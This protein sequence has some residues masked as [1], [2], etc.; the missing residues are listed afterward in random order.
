MFKSINGGKLPERGSKYSACV[1]VFANV[2]VVIGAGETKMIGLGVC[3]DLDNINKAVF[4]DFDYKTKSRLRNKG[5]NANATFL[6]TSKEKFLKSHYLQLMLR[7]SLGKKGLILPNGVG[8]IDMDYL[9]EIKMLIH[10]PFGNQLVG[11]PNETVFSLSDF[12]IVGKSFEIKKG[13]KIGQITLLEHKSFLFGIHS[14]EERT[15][16]FGSSGL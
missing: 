8:V 6:R 16:G 5:V 2:D 15:G 13:D 14:E 1:D 12:K 7:S 11:N 4:D 9:K 10:N 3:I